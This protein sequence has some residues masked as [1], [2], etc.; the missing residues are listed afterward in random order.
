MNDLIIISKRSM[1]QT[2]VRKKDNK[3]SFRKTTTYFMNFRAV[4]LT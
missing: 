4:S 3:F 2:A 1:K